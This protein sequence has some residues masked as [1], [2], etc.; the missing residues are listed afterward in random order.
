MRVG[1][2]LKQAHRLRKYY[3][4]P[5]PAGPFLA[6]VTR[7]RVQRGASDA[8]IAIV[9][10][11]HQIGKSIGRQIPVEKPATMQADIRIVVPQP[12]AHCRKPSYPEIEQC[13]IG[14]RRLVG[15]REFPD[16]LVVLCQCQ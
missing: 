10:H 14:V 6:P 15:Q 11:S 3:S 2:A 16:D 7:Q 9:Q 12:G 5:G 8:P 4:F 13:P 1:I